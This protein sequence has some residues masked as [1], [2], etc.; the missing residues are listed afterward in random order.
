MP[1]VTVDLKSG[2]DVQ[3]DLNCM[4]ALPLQPVLD[5]DGIALPGNLAVVDGA[6]R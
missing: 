6:S 5:L 2:M 3:T 4:S 1:P